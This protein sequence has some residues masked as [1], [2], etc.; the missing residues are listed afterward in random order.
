MARTFD[1]LIAKAKELEAKKA[2]IQASIEL[3]RNQI[4]TCEKDLVAK[5]GADYESKYES[6]VKELEEWEK[7]NA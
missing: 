5:Y 4:A 6:T 7:A 1:E 3:T 2:S